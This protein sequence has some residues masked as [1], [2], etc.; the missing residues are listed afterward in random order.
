MRRQCTEYERNV[1][2]NN[3]KNII[4]GNTLIRQN[5]GYGPIILGVVF[6]IVLSI[7][8][9]INMKLES[10]AAIK[11]FMIGLIAV[12]S[13][14]MQGFFRLIISA[15]NKK[16]AFL[17]GN[18]YINGCTVLG[19]NYKAGFFVYVEDDFWNSDGK[20]ARISFPLPD[21]VFLNVG[22]RLVAAIE[23]NG[24]YYLLKVDNSNANMIP[25]NCGYNL[26]DNSNAGILSECVIPHPNSVCLDRYPRSLSPEEKG[27]ILGSNGPIN[28]KKEV[29]IGICVAILYY[30]ITGLVW[31]VLVGDEIITDFTVAIIAGVLALLLGIG[32]IFLSVRLFRKSQRKLFSGDITVQSVMFGGRDTTMVG[33]AP[34][35]SVKI[36]EYV[37]DNLV[38]NTYPNPMINGKCDYGTIVYKYVMN[39]RVMFKSP[40]AK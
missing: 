7:P 8:I 31:I 12:M 4:S 17:E 35:D 26:F 1:L 25:Q 3:K 39:K 19:V 40:F 6:G 38:L 33:T 30:M 11:G 22:E 15:K 2:L 24:S 5:V 14:I 13:V 21:N 9:A 18:V 34:M 23:E 20:L 32:V 10:E 28:K 27:A 29:A 16:T 37:N 36:Y